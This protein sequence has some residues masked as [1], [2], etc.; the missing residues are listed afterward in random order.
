M[1]T[2]L[3]ILNF[4]VEHIAAE[5]VVVVAGVIFAR[6]IVATWEKWRYGRWHVIILKDHQTLLDREVSYPKAK[7][8]LGEP[9]ELSVFLKGV[10]SP[11]GWIN[12]DI[13]DEGIKLGLLRKD[14]ENRHF[15]INLD[16]NP[17]SGR[18]STR[19]QPDTPPNPPPIQLHI[20]I[21]QSSPS[22]NS[23]EIDT[24]EVML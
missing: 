19:A 14:V 9:S 16:H 7:E 17:Q 21:D 23:I 4:V 20:R 22:G 5:F 24:T 15:V 3:A 11:Y 10:V 2:L 8:I 18:E 6:F 12:C 13:L 1:D